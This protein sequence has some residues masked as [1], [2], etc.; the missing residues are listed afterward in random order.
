MPWIKAICGDGKIRTF[1]EC[2]NDKDH[3]CFDFEIRE[4]L[5]ARA[6]NPHSAHTG[7]SISAT[8]LL[9]C[10]RAT[11]LERIIDY[12]AS[13]QS[14]WFSLRGDLIHKIVERPRYEN[15]DGRR[16][17][18]KRL[19]LPVNGTSM[20]G[21]LDV[22][23][24]RFLVYRLLKDWKSIGDNGLRYIIQGGAKWDHIWQTNI[25]KTILEANEYP[26]DRIQIV[27]MSLMDV[28]TTGKPAVLHEFLVN[29]PKATGFRENMKRAEMV[30]AYPSGKHKWACHYDI[31]EV[32]IYKKQD[33]LDFIRP[34]VEIL[35]RAF[36]HEELPRLPDVSDVDPKDAKTLH[37]F[38]DIREGYWKCNG[39]CDVW[40]ECQKLTSGWNGP[41]GAEE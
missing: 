37:A 27:Y 29:E 36:E 10:L 15:E 21:Q 8:G 34:R 23:R 32:P 14:M 13:P 19:S 7:K 40:R 12:A 9:G 11:Y 24:E 16:E 3:P 39:Y 25:Y 35:Y 30:K 26:V 1:E 6:M 20:S 41:S 31:P 4:V 2:L 33:V 22:W 18:E 38:K 5:Y 28:V 17:T